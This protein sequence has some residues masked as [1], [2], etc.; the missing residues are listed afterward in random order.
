MGIEAPPSD[1]KGGRVYWN[2]NRKSF[3][4]I[5]KMPMYKTEKSIKWT[6]EKPSKKELNAALSAIDKYKD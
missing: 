5:R 4:V 1:Y 6:S 3:R 2:I